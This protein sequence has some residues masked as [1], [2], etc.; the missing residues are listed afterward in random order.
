MSEIWLDESNREYAIEALQKRFPGEHIVIL[1]AFDVAWVGWEADYQGALITHDAV[2]E[3]VVVD[4]T[5]H[6]DVA[7]EVHLRSKVLDYRRL[8]DATAA[9]LDRYRV[10][11]LARR[12]AVIDAATNGISEEQRASM[13]ETIAELQRRSDE[14]FDEWQTRYRR[15]EETGK[16]DIGLSG[17]G[18]S[19]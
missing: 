17:D 4:S 14:T 18:D 8:I 3:L 10:L 1:E 12:P 15:F 7:V 19:K 6:D 11:Q 13:L 16:L 9:V 2:P 5:G